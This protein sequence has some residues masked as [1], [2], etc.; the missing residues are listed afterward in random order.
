MRG[1]RNNFHLSLLI[2]YMSSILVNK[3]RAQLICESQHRANPRLNRPM[4]L[5]DDR[6]R[7]RNLITLHF[8]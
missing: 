6:R 3:L 7:Q 2:M 5:L 1:D 8:Q 4:I